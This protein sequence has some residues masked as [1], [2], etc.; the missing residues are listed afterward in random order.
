M[1][2]RY[3]GPP[4][5]S[6]TVESAGKVEL[7]LTR[8]S[9]PAGGL[10]AIATT[11]CW[12]SIRLPRSWVSGSGRRRMMGAHARRVAAALFGQRFSG[13]PRLV[14]GTLHTSEKDAATPTVCSRHQRP[15]WAA[16]TVPTSAATAACSQQK[17]QAVVQ[18]ALPLPL[19]PGHLHRGLQRGSGQLGPAA[20]GGH[21][22]ERGRRVAGG[23]RRVGGVS[24][25]RA[26]DCR[27]G[28][29]TC[30]AQPAWL[31]PLRACRTQLV[32]CA[33]A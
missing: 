2:R 8:S 18:A 1:L 3:V 12:L 14:N 10:R 11:L 24:A 9:R 15:C 4:R 23:V 17:A 30:L 5:G 19:W 31:Q 32:A 20:G 26:R 25:P 7:T 16:P 27:R 33:A 29:R 28:S 21:A 22:V 6:G 13:D